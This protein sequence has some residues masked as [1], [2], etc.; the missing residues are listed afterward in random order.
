[1]DTLKILDLSTLVLLFSTG[2]LVINHRLSVAIG[3]LAFQSLVLAFISVLV[4]TITGI[5][6]IYLAS[7]LTVLVKAI[8]AT[9]VLSFVLH[10]VKNRVETQVLSRGL[11]LAVAVGLILVSYSALNS[12]KLASTTASPNSLPVAISMVLIGL[13]IMVSRKKALMEVVG[14]ITI[15]NGLFLVALST[16]YGVPILVDFGIFFDVAIGVVMMGFFAFH[17][18]VLFETIDTDELNKLKG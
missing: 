11:S 7:I 18:N 3:L 16:T 15:E 4:G 10:K 5:T 8:G 9:V 14:L 17:I 6:D 1:M 2:L 13:F 12:V